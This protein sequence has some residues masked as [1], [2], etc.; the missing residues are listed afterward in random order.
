MDW[1]QASLGSEKRTQKFLQLMGA[2]KGPTGLA[3][4]KVGNVVRS[5]TGFQC[6]FFYHCTLPNVVAGIPFKIGGR[7]SSISKVTWWVGWSRG[8]GR[9]SGGL[10]A[11]QNA[12]IM[13]WHAHYELLDRTVC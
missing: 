2:G 6:P 3:K 13:R 1:S 8:G 7:F 4:K 5:K 10:R 11:S 12:I 9:G